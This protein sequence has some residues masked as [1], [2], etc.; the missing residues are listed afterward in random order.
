M[1]P[2]R[3]LRIAAVVASPD[4]R[5]KEVFLST[6]VRDSI[7]NSIGF[8]VSGAVELTNGM[9]GRAGRIEKSNAGQLNRRILHAASSQEA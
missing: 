1:L 4:V 7:D 6:W 5:L 3:V 9:P 8:E 2:I